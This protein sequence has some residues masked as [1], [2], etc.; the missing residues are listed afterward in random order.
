MLWRYRQAVGSTGETHLGPLAALVGVGYFF[1]WIVFGMVAF[2]LDVA[3][4][5]AEIQMP[6]L[7]RAVRSAVGVIVIVAGAGR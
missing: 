3:L 4:T 5:A 6:A 7:T 1:V 2:P